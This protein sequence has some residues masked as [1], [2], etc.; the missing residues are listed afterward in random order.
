MRRTGAETPAAVAGPRFAGRL[1]RALL[2]ALAIALAPAAAQAFCGQAGQRACCVGENGYALGGCSASAVT[3]PQANA[4]L[5]SGFNPFGIQASAICVAP[6]PCGN[7]F[8]RACCAGESGFTFGGCY[9]GL[10]EIPQADSGYCTNSTLGVQSSGVCVPITP[11]GA[12]GQRACCAGESGFGACQSGLVQLPQPN[13]GQCS[14]LL[15]GIQSS[16]VCAAVTPCGGTNQRACCVGENGFA[17]GGCGGGLNQ[18]P[19]PN[20]GQCSNYAPGIQSSGV[21]VPITPCGALGQRACCAG[22]AGF[23]ACQSGLVQLPQPNSG[24]CSNLLPGIQSSGVCAAVT[25]CG[26]AGQ[27]ACCVGENGFAFG[28][29]STGNNQVP[30]ANS[31][32]CS[33]YAPGIQSSGMCVPITPCGGSGQR[34]CCAGEAAFG[35]CQAGL[36]QLPQPN[37]GQCSNL[38]PGIQ[39]SGICAPVT[40]CGGAGERAC[41]A[42]ENGFAFGGCSTGN[43]QVPQPNSG[44]CSNLAPG[45]QSSGICVPITPCG[46]DGQ[47]ACCAGE[48]GFPLGGCG[49]GLSELPQPNSGQCS[50]LLPGIQSSGVC[51]PVTPCGGPGERACCVTESV[52]PC[53]SASGMAEV[54]LANQGQCAGAAPGIQSA[55]FCAPIAPCGGEGQR[56]CCDLEGNEFTAGC[57]PGLTAIPGCSGDCTCSAGWL[58]PYDVSGAMCARMDPIAEPGTNWSPP[59]QPPASPLRG[60]ADLHVHAFAHLAHGG[61]VFSGMPY[62]ATGGV[63]DALKQD[64]GTNLLLVDRFGVPQPPPTCPS[65]LPNC[66]LRLFHGDHPI[67]GAGNDQVGVGT[68]DGGDRF[69]FGAE[70]NLGAPVF[71]G[72]P[73]WTTTTHQQTY[74][75]W[76]ERAW[77]GGMRLMVMLAVTNEALC[78]TS[79]RLLGTDCADGMA[80][81]R[82][83]LAEASALQDYIDGLSGGP[84]Q[85]WF[86]IVRSPAEARQVIEDGKL[87]VVLGIEMD[88][89]FNCKFDERDPKTGFCTDSSVRAWVDEMHTLGV[90]HMFPVHNF[91]N[92][93]GSPAT[94]QDAIHIGNRGVEG[95]WWDA[96]DCPGEEYGFKLNDGLF[97]VLGNLFL[98][99]FGFGVV[100]VPPPPPGDASCN[101]RG[102]TSLGTVLIDQMIR[103]GM[104][105]DVDHMSAKAFDET[106][107]IAR[108]YSPPYPVVASHVQFLALNQESISHERMRTPGQLQQIKDVG[109]MVA[110]MLKDDQQDTDNIGR[111][112]N[113]PFA[114]LPDDC[115]HSSKTWAQMYRYAV[116]MMGNAPVAF[117]SDFNGVAGHIGPRFGHDACGGEATAIGAPEKEARLAE[118]RAQL[119]EPDLDYPFTIPGFGS[120]DRQ[121]TGQ[122]TFDFNVDGLAHIGLLPDLIADLTVI[123]LTPSEIDP[124]F[125]SAEAYVAMWERATS[126]FCPNGPGND[127]DGDGVGDA[128]DNCPFASN[129][130]QLDTGGVGS[131]SPGDGIGDACQCGDVN[132]DGR[133]TLADAVTVTRSLIVPPTAVQARPE[134]CDVNASGT[135]SLPDAV[136]IRRSLLAPPTA[137]IEQSCAPARP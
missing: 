12:A 40:P 23:G 11:C 136:A 25:P 2:A 62:S 54:P 128:C 90:R 112:F 13:S 3:V 61:G 71:N 46:G 63:N 66:G 32:Q 42:G 35:D 76:M 114:S 24:Q 132:D 121:V 135:C 115:R 34:A 101:S 99:L 108:S 1:A 133:V 67:A 51:A 19:Q 126:A 38:L 70:S 39:S 80:S 98:T 87:A 111:K 83:Q 21:C 120:F 118:R 119:Q 105:I 16:G 93:F 69:L 84:G 52:F 65:F 33:N 55:G 8:E 94:W 26:G 109:G 137:R 96:E 107:A 37:S 125:R 104:L 75:A 97:S 20:S 100:D 91:D 28:G 22:E 18:V 9:N 14:N 127:A 48:N 30:Q 6:T 131:G 31:G 49:A 78:R 50:N 117:G 103:R 59:A 5:C 10:N 60:F 44:Q 81:I 73:V 68:K 79:K 88:N 122:K 4:G 113:V 116:E 29:C 92:A 89:L 129:T 17:F 56:A 124:L 15:P 53:D 95:K 130:D 72:W 77:R 82:A 85:G 43:N 110:A 106:L 36:V 57:D 123:G 86:R 134:L 7:T 41:C 74:H 102:L 27:R 58:D 45:I 64:Y 47:R